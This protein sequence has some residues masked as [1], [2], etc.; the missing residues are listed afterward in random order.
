MFAPTQSVRSELK[1]LTPVCSDAERDVLSISHSKMKNLHYLIF[2]LLLFTFACNKQSPESPQK[3]II[4][5]EEAPAS[6]GVYS[7]AVQTGNTLY[8]SGQIGLIPGTRELAGEDLGAQAHQT[9][10]NIQ[11]VLNA[12]GFSLPDVVKAQVFL[13]DI[14]D[15]SAFNEIYVQYFTENPPARAV[16][17]VSRI[18]LDAKVEIMIT[19][20]K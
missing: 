3:K 9:L 14:E 15:Y 5:T 20:V 13:D 10:Q 12:A 4:Q 18:P 1:N 16:V 11:A 2:P 6:I 7:Q 19:A 8:L 17:E